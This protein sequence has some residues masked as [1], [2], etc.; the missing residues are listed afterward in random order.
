MKGRSRMKKDFDPYDMVK[1]RELHPRADQKNFV[2]VRK[3]NLV[4]RCGGK[5]RRGGFCKSFAGSGTDHPGYGRCK[6]CGGKS[7]G[8][9]TEAGKEKVGQNANKHGLYSKVL[10]DREK[11][12]YH[13]ILDS[14]GLVSLKEEIAFLRT[15]IITYLERWMLKE[16]GGGYDSTK[17]WYKDG[18]EKAFYHAGSIEDRPLMRAYNELGRLVEKQARLT[19]ENKDDILSQINEELRAASQKESLESWSAFLPPHSV[20]NN[21]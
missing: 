10:S 12:T 6:Y 19:G 4:L 8:P 14:D 17:Q 16:R 2:D 20:S 13:K 11:D 1:K 21:D 18:N 3:G 15:K 7:T 5:K 9:K